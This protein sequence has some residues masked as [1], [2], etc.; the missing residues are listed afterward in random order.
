MKKYQFHELSWSGKRITHK[1]NMN[2]VIES[3]GNF[4]IEEYEWNEHIY[5]LYA[6]YIYIYI[7]VIHIYIVM[8]LLLYIYIK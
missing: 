6:I 3:S 7:Y 1:H 4:P 5:M 2:K 8:Y